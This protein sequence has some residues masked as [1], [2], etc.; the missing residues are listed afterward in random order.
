LDLHDLNP[1]ST[2]EVRHISRVISC[3]VA[4]IANLECGR[5]ENIHREPAEP[6]SHLNCLEDPMFN[7][8]TG[9]NQVNSRGFQPTTPKCFVAGV[10]TLQAHPQSLALQLF[11]LQTFELL[12]VSEQFHS[13]F[14]SLGLPLAIIVCK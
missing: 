4:Y 6:N 8:S 12:Q 2:G 10:L 5:K 14:F 9:K 1:V 13:F 11:C 7:C 3:P